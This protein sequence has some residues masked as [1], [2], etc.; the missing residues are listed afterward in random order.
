MLTGSAAF[1]AI[2]G[3]ANDMF[4][5]FLL[6]AGLAVGIMLISHS[7]AGAAYVYV[8]V[9]PPA[10]IVETVPARPGAGYVWVGGYYRWNGAHYVWVPGRYA[11]HAG[12]WCPGHWA[13]DPHGYYW[14]EGRWC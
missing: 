1:A 10:A 5:K 14:V 12:R 6:T 13:H 7:S 8:Q 2:A 9:G 3:K 11:H 4:K